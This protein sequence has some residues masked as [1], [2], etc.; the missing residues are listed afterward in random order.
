MKLFRSAE[1]IP[2]AEIKFIF[3]RSKWLKDALLKP[4]ELKD[5]WLLDLLYNT[6]TG[7]CIKL[8][9]IQS[10]QNESIRTLLFDLK[11]LVI[12]L[13]HALNFSENN[14]ITC[15]ESVTLLFHHCN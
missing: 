13:S 15:R 2:V 5:C 11:F 14:K 10:L 4:T 8:S 3:S 9:C 7:I 6:L 1:F 12:Q